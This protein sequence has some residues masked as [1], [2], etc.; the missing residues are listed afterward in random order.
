MRRFSWLVR[1]SSFTDDPDRARLLLGTSTIFSIILST[2]FYTGISTILST[3]FSTSIIF[4]TSTILSTIFST[5][6]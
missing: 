3:I 5:I 1:T 6:I 2:I 4:S